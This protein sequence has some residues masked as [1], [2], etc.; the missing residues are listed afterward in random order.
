MANK[1]LNGV[2][3][4]GEYSLPDVDGTNGQVM[5]TD[6]SG[7]VT[8]ED[9]TAGVTTLSALTDVE[10]VDYT[11]GEILVADGDSFNQV[12]MSGDVTI[13]GTGA[14]TL[15]TS[16]ILDKIK[17]SDDFVIA[18]WVGGAAPYTLA[19]TQATHGLSA[20]KNLMV[21]V[22]EDLGTNNEV[23]NVNAV[24]TDGGNV[25]LSS[26]VKIDGSITIIG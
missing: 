18:D 4:N 23:V 1:F 19:Y 21:Q 17:Y 10:N 11:S 2:N 25:T 13:D 9:D 15:S 12:A 26:M 7:V 8:W 20:S 6:G 14:T 3:V 22:T 16:G 5:K 24:I